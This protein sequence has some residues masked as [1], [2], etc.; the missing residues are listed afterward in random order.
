MARKRTPRQRQT[1]QSPNK[2]AKTGEDTEEAV[3]PVKS[4]TREESKQVAQAPPKQVDSFPIFDGKVMHLCIKK[5]DIANRIVFCADSW[6]AWKLARFFDNPNKCIYV[7]SPRHFECYTG[8]FQGV[9][10]T[11]LASGMGTPMFDFAIREGKF[12]IDG[13]MAICRFGLCASIADDVEVG[14]VVVQD[15]GSFHVQTD[16]DKLH[17]REDLP[18][19]IGKVQKADE[20]LSAHLSKHLEHSTTEGNFKRGLN[21]TTDSFYSSQCRHDPKFE[22]NNQGLIHAIKKAHPEAKTLE[23]ENYVLYALSNIA[24]KQ[25]VHVAS[26]SIVAFSS[27]DREKQ[28]SKPK[29]AELED[30]V[31]YSMFKALADFDFPQGEPKFTVEMINA[32]K[33]KEAELNGGWNKPLPYERLKEKNPGLFE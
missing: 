27:Q 13:P 28:L 8:L 33:A 6:R 30:L 20:H 31:G 25:D 24:K 1:R 9:P 3:S 22:D 21:G 23:M 4:E 10:I 5:G 12:C 17:D 18:Y 11:V 7:N 19:K 29:R 26:T 14:N 16:F 32:V 15:K 2:R